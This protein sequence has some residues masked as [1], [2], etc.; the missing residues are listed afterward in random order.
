MRLR[1]IALGRL[2]RLS[3]RLLRSTLYWLVSNSWV[4]RVVRLVGRV[5]WV[6][7]GLD[8]WRSLIDWG[9]HNLRSDH[10]WSSNDRRSNNWSYN[11]GWH[12]SWLNY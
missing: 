11:W 2:V 10:R 1:L 4:S 6:E 5:A 3:G 7:W 9:A 12:N 8:H